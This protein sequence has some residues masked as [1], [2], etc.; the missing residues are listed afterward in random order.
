MRRAFNVTLN[1]LIVGRLSEDDSGRTSFRLTDEYK[2]IARRPV[3]SQAF[4]DDLSKVYR[5][6]HSELPAYFANLVPEG[7]L[8]ELIESSL[9]LPHGDDLAL[10]QAVGNDLPGAV[11]I[12]SGSG[13]ADGFAENGEEEPLPSRDAETETG[14]LRFSLAGVQLKFSVLRE[15][16][17][18]A[19]PVHGQRGEWIAKL[20]SSRFPSVVENELSTLEWARAAGFDV[21]ECSLKP[22]ASLETALRGYANPETSVLVIRRYDRANGRRIH[23]EDFAQVVNLPPRLK[24]D[25][26]TY[27]QCAALILEIINEEAYFEF[28]RRLAFMVACG[29]ND[30]HLKNWSLVYP[31]GI[32]A[33]LS[34][35]YDQ[36]C[37]IAWPELSPELA[38][39]FAGLKLL[40]RVD[41]E[42]FARLAT[43][44]G[45]D[46]A[47]TI[48]VLR[49]SLERIAAAWY[50]SPARHVMP[51]EH[52]AAL[53]EY[54]R[55]SA[56]LK[57]YVGGV[58]SPAR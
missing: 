5:G 53:Q 50:E 26:V 20:D 35:L 37:T 29:N 54:W 18:L 3:L 8:R 39:K 43:R 55:G 44:A 23:Q 47:K 38:L 41:E 40:S 2:N 56:L 52:A 48:R 12:S 15:G 24:Y 28:V 27:E 6:K 13:E 9:Q 33:A 16:E 36:V 19:L 31:D 46:A 30:A 10:L 21:P 57:H 7:P 58:G 42:A 49:D 17:K 11:E 25:H 14:A 34:P 4:E 22:A 51:P 45:A 32:N 1:G